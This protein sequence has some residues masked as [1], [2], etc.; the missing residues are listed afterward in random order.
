MHIIQLFLKVDIDLKRF[1]LCFQYTINMGN[2]KLILGI[3]KTEIGDYVSSEFNL[4]LYGSYEG[5]SPPSMPLL[6]DKCQGSSNCVHIL[7][8][9]E[10]GIYFLRYYLPEYLQSFHP[11]SG[12]VYIPERLFILLSLPTKVPLSI[13][14]GYRVNRVRIS[15]PSRKFPFPLAPMPLKINFLKDYEH[16][17]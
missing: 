7:P 10:G 14:P 6:S 2:F 15:A 8:V 17:S 16:N 4:T 3:L 9:Q 12:W 5:G 1:L 13:L 11:C